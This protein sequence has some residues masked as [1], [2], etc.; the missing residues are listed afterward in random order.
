MYL[1]AWHSIGLDFAVSE[2]WEADQGAHAGRQGF[3]TGRSTGP[4]S[5]DAWAH[6]MTHL[7]SRVGHTASLILPQD[8]GSIRLVSRLIPVPIV[9]RVGGSN[10]VFVGHWSYH[11]QVSDAASAPRASDFELTPLESVNQ[12]SECA[13]DTVPYVVL[14]PSRY[15][16]DVQATAANLEPDSEPRCLGV[17]LVP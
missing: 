13:V 8:I 10:V 6:C 11:I 4:V 7:M 2:V 9:L 3:G 5:V 16:F 14:V 15:G 17:C 12:R 1:G